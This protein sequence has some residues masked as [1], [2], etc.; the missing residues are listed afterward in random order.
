MRHHCRVLLIHE[1]E[2][3]VYLIWTDDELEEPTDEEIKS[4]LVCFY[5]QDDKDFY[6]TMDDL[7]HWIEKNYQYAPAWVDS[8]EIKEIVL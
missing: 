1:G 3:Y 6:T 2:D 5:Q 7:M 4:K 8:N